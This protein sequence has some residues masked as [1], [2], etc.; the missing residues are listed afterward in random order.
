MLRKKLPA[1]AKAMA[2]TAGRAEEGKYLFCN[3]ALIC[4]KNIYGVQLAV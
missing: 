3:T 4:G 1:V 2:D